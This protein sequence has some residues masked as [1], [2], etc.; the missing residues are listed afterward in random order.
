MHVLRVSHCLLLVY[1]KLT[2]NL[3]IDAV[4]DISINQALKNT[5]WSVTRMN[6]KSILRIKRVNYITILSHEH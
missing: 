3:I 4:R 2:Y 5:I 6:M 1:L